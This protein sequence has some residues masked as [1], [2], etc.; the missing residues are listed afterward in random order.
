MGA[1]ATHLRLGWRQVVARLGV[2]GRHIEIEGLE[3]SSV[4]VGNLMLLAMLDEQQGA[5]AEEKPP[6][7]RFGDAAASDHVEPLICCPVPIFRALRIP[8]RYRPYGVLLRMRSRS[9]GWAVCF[10]SSEFRF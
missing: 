6:L 7:A 5:L 2:R 4:I 1:V 9:L 8:G 10:G 3:R